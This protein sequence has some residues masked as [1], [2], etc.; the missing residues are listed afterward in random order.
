MNA[1]QLYSYLSDNFKLLESIDNELIQIELCEFYHGNEYS[2]ECGYEYRLYFYDMTAYLVIKTYYNEI[3]EEG[4]NDSYNNITVKEFYEGK[5]C[6]A[7]EIYEKI[8]Q[9][10]K[11]AT[12]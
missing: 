6:N 1:T 11:N 5:K 7:D 12:K 8:Q 3:D 10:I 9:A 4:Y 2:N